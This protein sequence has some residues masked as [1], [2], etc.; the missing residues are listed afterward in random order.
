MKG[1]LQYHR[2]QLE[3]SQRGRSARAYVNSGHLNAALIELQEAIATA[4]QNLDC[5]DVANA[6]Q[7]PALAT[8]LQACK[9]LS[10]RGDEENGRIRELNTRIGILMQ[11]RTTRRS[12]AGHRSLT[13]RPA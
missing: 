6:M 5:A 1:P 13:W 2:Y 12:A 11:G 3:I 10:D 4:E 7:L 8:I 9:S